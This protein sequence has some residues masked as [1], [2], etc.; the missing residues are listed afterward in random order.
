MLDMNLGGRFH[1]LVDD[2]AN[3]IL[4]AS[5]ITTCVPILVYILYQRLFSP[6]A[7][8]DGPFWASLSPLWKLYNVNKGT[9]HETIIALHQKYGSIVRIAPTEVI[10]SDR[11]AIKEI[12]STI[13]GR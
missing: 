4:V 12:Y 3:H 8:V 5:F 2:A 13:Q 10:I 1:Q 11:T 6:L 9:F 7:K